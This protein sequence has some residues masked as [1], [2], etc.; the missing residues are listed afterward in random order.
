MDFLS[1]SNTILLCIELHLFLE[2]V[3]GLDSVD[4][5]SKPEAFGFDAS[6]P[7]PDMW[8]LE[9]NPSY[10]YYLFY[11]YANLLALNYLRHLRGMNTLV[12]RPHAG[13]AGPANH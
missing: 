3:T 10:S 5:E 13:E 9:A 2:H 7:P 12:F 11:M 8:T 1:I 6:T 4:D